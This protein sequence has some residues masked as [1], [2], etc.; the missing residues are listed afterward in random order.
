MRFPAG[1]PTDDPP[2]VCVDDEGDIDEA[3]PGRDIG[4]IREPQTVW[5]GSVEL[6]VHVIQRTESC[7]VADRCPQ[8]FA[9]DRPLKAHVPH[10]PGDC[11]ASGAEAFPPQ[12]TPD[13]AH[14]MDAEILLEPP[15][16]ARNESDAGTPASDG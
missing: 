10:Q 7:L 16:S 1:P 4:K 6:S 5:S 12:L 3:G 8:R 13:L 9:P 2:G 14:A 15:R 11:A